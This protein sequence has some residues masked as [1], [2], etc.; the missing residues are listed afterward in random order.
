M[1]EYKYIRPKA[2]ESNEKFEKRLNEACNQ[3]WKPIAISGPQGNIVLLQ[4]IE[5]HNC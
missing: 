3:G 1:E 4:K 5:K 2:F